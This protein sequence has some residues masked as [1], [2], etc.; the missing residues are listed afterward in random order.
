MIN[1]VVLVFKNLGRNKIRTASTSMAVTVLVTIFAVVTNVTESV[2]RGVEA[3][4]SQTKLL[5]NERWVIPSKVPVRYI[6][7]ISR[8][9]GV[10]DWTTWNLYPGGSINQIKSLEWP[11]AWTISERCMPGLKTSTWPPSRLSRERK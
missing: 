8:I 6:P 9:P 3:D 1:F 2:R 11:L 10:E 4:A 7:E 5:V